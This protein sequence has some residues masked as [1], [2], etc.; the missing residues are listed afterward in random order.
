MQ[1]IDQSILE[2]LKTKQ[3]NGEEFYRCAHDKKAFEQ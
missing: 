3:I 1:M 2:L